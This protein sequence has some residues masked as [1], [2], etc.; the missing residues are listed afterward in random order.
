MTNTF[1]EHDS[2]FSLRPLLLKV[3]GASSG[4]KVFL[5]AIFH[6]KMKQHPEVPHEGL[7]QLHTS[8]SSQWVSHDET[9]EKFFLEDAE[10]M[11]EL[12]FHN[13]YDHHRNNSNNTNKRMKIIT[14]AETRKRQQQY[15]KDIRLHQQWEGDQVALRS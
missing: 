11:W 13:G 1:D 4:A 10:K 2:S 15:K 8:G 9:G 3:I 12:Y 14:V 7:V 6:S 5:V